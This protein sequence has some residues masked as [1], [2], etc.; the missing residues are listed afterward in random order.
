MS[1]TH[2]LKATV[3]V[4]MIVSTH[5]R[6][7][8]APVAAAIHFRQMESHVKVSCLINLESMGLTEWVVLVFQVTA[9]NVYGKINESPVTE[10]K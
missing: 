10:L 7:Q 4:N 5:H 8:F 2:V 1:L 3:D 9:V 6:V